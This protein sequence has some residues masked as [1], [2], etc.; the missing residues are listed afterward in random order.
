V[1]LVLAVQ[2]YDNFKLKMLDYSIKTKAIFIGS[3]VVL[4]AVL[5]FLINYNN[6]KARDLEM[7]T[8][9]RHLAT[10]MENYFAINYSYPEV[11]Q[12]DIANISVIS[13]NGVNKEGDYIYFKKSK[14]V[15]PGLLT[16]MKDR[17][18]IEFDLNHSWDT[19]E[20]KGGG[21]CKMSNYLEMLCQSK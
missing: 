2:L 15:M 3:L 11:D 6:S 19:W 17:Y 13:E 5:I 12:M 4:I 18:I 16:S 20:L 8:Q 21:T 14:W 7:L 10:S 9:V 1:T